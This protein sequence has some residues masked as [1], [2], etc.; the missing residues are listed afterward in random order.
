MIKSN[1]EYLSKRKIAC[2]GF[3]GYAEIFIIVPPYLTHTC[4]NRVILLDLLFPLPL[5]STAIIPP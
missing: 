4:L 3:K 2:R 5:T 1:Q